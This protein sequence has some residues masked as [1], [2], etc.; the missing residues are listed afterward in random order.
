MAS[1]DASFI[2]GQYLIVDGGFSI[3]S[4]TG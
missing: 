4:K 1:K 2:T 3:G